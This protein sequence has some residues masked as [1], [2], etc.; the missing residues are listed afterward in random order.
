MEVPGRWVSADRD[1]TPAFEPEA[2]A[3]LDRAPSPGYITRL[4]EGHNQP[5][6]LIVWLIGKSFTEGV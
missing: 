1:A 5:G 2:A 4:R 3:F 6:A